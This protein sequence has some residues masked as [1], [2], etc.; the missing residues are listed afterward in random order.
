[1]EPPRPLKQPILHNSTI[2]KI[3]AWSAHCQCRCERKWLKCDFGGDYLIAECCWFAPFTYASDASPCCHRDDYLSQLTYNTL[4]SYLIVQLRIW[5]ARHISE[6]KKITMVI[7]WVFFLFFFFAEW[8]VIYVF[9]G[10]RTKVWLHRK[11]VTGNVVSSNILQDYR[12]NLNL[13]SISP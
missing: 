8:K 11:L 3:L 5:K 10:G 2:K 13:S 4:S 1:M 9:Y 6:K 7:S 12:C